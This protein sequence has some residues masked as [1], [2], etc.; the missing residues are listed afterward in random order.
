MKPAPEVL[1]ALAAKFEHL[2]DEAS[3]CASDLSLDQRAPRSAVSTAFAVGTIA[4]A[5]VAVLR[6][7][8]AGIHGPELSPHV[9]EASAKKAAP[10]PPAR[11]SAPRPPPAPAKSAEQ[12]AQAA[13]L[14]ISKVGR[15]G[16]AK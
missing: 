15:A 4:S 8:A 9:L 6:A 1:H 10:V 13:H 11:P 5:A 3:V 12:L 16:G 14:A 7:A 2:V